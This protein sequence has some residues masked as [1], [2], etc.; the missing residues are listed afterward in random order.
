MAGAGLKETPVLSSGTSTFTFG[1]VALPHGQETAGK[2]STDQI[3]D[4]DL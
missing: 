3:F 4:N 2:P 1:Q